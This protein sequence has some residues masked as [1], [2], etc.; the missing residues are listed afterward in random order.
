MVEKMDAA[1]QKRCAVREASRPEL[2]SMIEAHYLG[3]W[4]GVCVARL[5]LL[6]DGAPVGALIFALP[7]RETSARYGRPTWELARLWV[8]DLMPRNTESWF[9]AR[10]VRWVKQNRPEIGALV[11]YADPS[12]GHQGVIYRA[13]NWQSDGRTDDERKTPRFDYTH[14]VTGKKYARRKHV[15]SDVEPVRVPRVSKARF[16]YFLG[17]K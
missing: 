10:A 2:Q 3:K 5:A 13:A 9:I 6:L 4:P 11:S 16:V 7:P 17:K 1:L 12:A 15:P 8:D 14:P